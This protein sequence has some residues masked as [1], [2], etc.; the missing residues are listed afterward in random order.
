M[1]KFTA[2]SIKQIAEMIQARA[3]EQSEDV[4]QEGAQ[5]A[6]QPLPEARTGSDV[7]P[8]LDESSKEPSSAR[9]NGGVKGSVT[10][11]PAAH[12]AEDAASCIR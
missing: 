12:V 2:R 5:P 9:A 6:P 10:S 1:T 8:V 7:S 4:V 11:P 3:N